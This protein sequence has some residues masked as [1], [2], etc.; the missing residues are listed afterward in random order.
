MLYLAEVKKQTRTFMG[1]SKSELRLLACLHN[2]QTWSAL[3]GDESIS[4]EESQQQFTEGMLLLVNL[5]NNRQLQG[6]PEIAAPKLIRQLQRIS[7]LL[8]KSKEDQEKIEQWRESLNVQ[9][10]ELSRRQLE[11]EA[12]QEQLEQMEAEFE[13]LERQK[14]QLEEAQELLKQ[15]Q[16]SLLEGQAKF[17]KA[18]ELNPE[19]SSRLQTLIDRLSDHHNNG[20]SPWQQVYIARELTESHQK[21]LTEYWNSLKQKQENLQAK[22]T[23]QEQQAR[24]VAQ[25]KQEL[26]LL[27]NS[28]QDALIQFKL[29]QADL[30]SKQNL[31]TYVNLGLNNLKNTRSILLRVAMGTESGETV[32]SQID[33][34]ALESMPLGE[35]ENNVKQQQAELDKLVRFVNEQEEELTL[36]CQTVEELKTR[37]AN[38]MSFDRESINQELKYEEER[39]TMLDETLVGQRRTLRERQAVLLQHLRVLRRRQGNWQFNSEEPKM[40]FDPILNNLEDQQNELREQQQGLEREVENLQNGLHQIQEMI[41]H[42]NAEQ[43]RKTQE[44]QHLEAQWQAGQEELI[45]LRSKV[46]LYEQI[47]QPLQSGMN[48]LN[49]QLQ[50]LEQWFEPK[51]FTS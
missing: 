46:N 28:L 10:Q 27:S 12:Q 26:E 50:E 35:L 47:L 51:A 14:R 39:K 2:D 13:V 24:T 31:L 32:E 45:E 22:Q 44:I 11:I 5:G 3:S 42:Q 17:G 29:Q 8:E 43:Q 9:M 40:N 21:E 36:Q 34:A 33:L 1:G 15:Q 49:Q 48:R 19:Q 18:L 16:Q 41:N 30:E 23:A 38:A 37:L 20:Q 4:W 7:Q 6:S 25:K